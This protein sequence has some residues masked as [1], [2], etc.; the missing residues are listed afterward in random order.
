MPSAPNT[1]VSLRRSSP[2]GG[3]GEEVGREMKEEAMIL[4]SSKL[5]AKQAVFDH[6]DE[7]EDEMEMMAEKRSVKKSVASMVRR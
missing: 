2:W 7:G 3:E 6:E 4:A 5:A 1:P